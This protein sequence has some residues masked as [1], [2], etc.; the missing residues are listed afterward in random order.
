M[1]KN[2]LYFTLKYCIL[3]ACSQSMKLGRKSS[4]IDVI[5]SFGEGKFLVGKT[6]IVTGGNSG[7]GLETCKALSSAGCR[8]ILCSRS[9]S[10]AEKALTEEIMRP[11]LGG[12]IVDDVNNIIIKEL[13]L[14]NF[15]SIKSFADDFLTFN[16]GTLDFLILNA[17]IMA[18]PSLSYTKTGFEKQLGEIIYMFQFYSYFSFNAMHLY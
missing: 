18:V 13:D 11:G 5:R 4:A 17:G 14:E 15:S 1:L 7:I 16:K 9:K 8:V 2:L 3:L 12:Y 6:A 10:A